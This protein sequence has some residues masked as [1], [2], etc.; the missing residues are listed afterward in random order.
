MI[1]LIPARCVA[2]SL[3]KRCWRECGGERRGLA[4]ISCYH[5][6]QPP[7]EEN[8]SQFMAKQRVEMRNPFLKE[9]TGEAFCCFKLLRL[10]FAV[11]GVCKKLVNWK[12]QQFLAAGLDSGLL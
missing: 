2:D 8:T 9:L 3:I 7:H 5:C 11:A 4:G 10:H 6:Q 12:Q 1:R